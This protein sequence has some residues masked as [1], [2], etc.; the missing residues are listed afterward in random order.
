MNTPWYKQF[1]P[2]FLISLPLS[3]VIGGIATLIIAMHSPNAMVV[4]DYYKEGLAINEIL[5]QERAAAELGLSGLL[6]YAPGADDVRLELMSPNADAVPEYLELLLVHPTLADKD[7]SLRLEAAVRGR[8]LAAM[9][10][11]SPGN[12]HLIVSPPDGSW[13]LTGRMVLPQGGQARLT[14]GV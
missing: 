4:D 10:E 3:A 1:W 2:W 14:P 13:R 7:Q 9:P 11:L 6:R 8:Y 5:A 12:W